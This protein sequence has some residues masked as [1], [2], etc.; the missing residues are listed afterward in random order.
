M[1]SQ[2]QLPNSPLPLRD[3]V[4]AA[5]VVVVVAADNDDK[6]VAS[7]EAENVAAALADVAV[8]FLDVA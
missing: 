4:V 3:D 6:L 8:A 5:A 1:Q 7:F 2:P